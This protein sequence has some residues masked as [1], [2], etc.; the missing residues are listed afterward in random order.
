[1]RLR[2]ASEACGANAPTN[3]SNSSRVITVLQGPFAARSLQT[4]SSVTTGV[5]GGT[6]S[7]FTLLAGVPAGVARRMRDLWIGVRGATPC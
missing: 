5:V 7:A 4:P 6:S 1:M 3:L 2:I